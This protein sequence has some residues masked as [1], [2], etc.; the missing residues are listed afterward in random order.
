MLAALAVDAKAGRGVALRI[1]IEDQHGLADGGE[2][3]AQIDRGR[4]LADAALLVG[5]G[6]NARRLAGH[7]VGAQA[8]GKIDDLGSDGRFGLGVGHRRI[9]AGWGQN[10]P[11]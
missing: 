1:E 8:V 2:C 3:G 7:G 5:D 10:R 9:L 6:E 4:G 11:G